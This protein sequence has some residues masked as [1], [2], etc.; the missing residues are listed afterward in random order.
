M[1][2]KSHT[3]NSTTISEQSK[4]GIYGLLKGRIEEM[5]I[6]WVI[7]VI[8][9]EEGK[10]KG[11]PIVEIKA[12]R[13]LLNTHIYLDKEIFQ[14]RKKDRSVICKKC[15]QFGHLKKYC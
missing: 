5:C 10:I 13:E 6:E 11:Q 4:L 14:R 1:K 3:K 2:H 15:L 7:Q 9:L 12:N 8:M